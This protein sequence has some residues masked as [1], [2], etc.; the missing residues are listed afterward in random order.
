VD[1]DRRRICQAGLALGCSALVPACGSSSN[2]LPTCSSG[3]V[4]AGNINDVADN[5]AVKQQTA[6]VSVFI[7]HDAGGYYAL[8]AGCTHLGCDVQPKDGADLAQ[9]FICICHGATYD[10]NGL[11]P[12]A[13]APSPLR[14]YL[15]CVQPSGTLLVDITAQGVDPSTRLKL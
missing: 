7:C 11:N 6:Q 2:T 9:G 13:P 1:R 3:A 10:A 8:D 14:H 15:L 5:R 4:A 12:T